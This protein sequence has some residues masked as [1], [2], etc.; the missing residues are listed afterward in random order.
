MIGDRSHDVLGARAN[1]VAA[2]GVTWGY[3]TRDE[4]TQAGA[5]ALC[6]KPAELPGLAALR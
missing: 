6:D 5:L 3:G 2:L 4:L 1:Q